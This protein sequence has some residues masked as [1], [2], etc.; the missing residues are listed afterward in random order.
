MKG[1]IM[2][3]KINKELIY[4]F[5][6]SV[7]CIVSI[8]S[9][10]ELLPLNEYVKNGMYIFSCVL[11][12]IIILCNKYTKKEYIIFLLLLLLTL[13]T[14]IKIHKMLFLINVLAIM[15][16]KNI[17]ID[18]IIKI[19]IILKTVIIFVHS[20][21]YLYQYIFQY[22]QIQEL[23]ITDAGRNRHA[24]YFI[25]PNLIGQLVLWLAIDILYIKKCTNKSILLSTV[26]IIIT[27]IITDSRTMLMIYGL[28]LFL[29]YI[30][31]VIKQKTYKNIIHFISKYSIDMIAILSLV[32]T[33][34][35][36]YKLSSVGL[37]NKLTSGR[38]YSSYVAIEKF[39]IHLMPNINAINLDEFIIIDN[40]YIRSAILFGGI[41]I[42]L[43]SIMNKNISKNESLFSKIIIIVFSI[44][45]FSEFNS[46][47]IGNAIPIL[48]LGYMIMNKNKINL[49]ETEEDKMKRENPV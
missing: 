37:I 39:G 25:H 18:N 33:L 21:A 3:I 23:I 17:K 27:Y 12:C 40:F 11:F 4:I 9:S 31:M 43:L 24:M 13:Y 10:S 42:I 46:I 28:F 16:I 45:L 30:R 35:Y 34:L 19:D 20:I 2:K 49:L 41:F 26:L 5:A 44:N 22:E 8:L 36:K 32:L 47:C 29:Y 1:I 7:Y 14:S 15:A 38:I 48:L 6:F